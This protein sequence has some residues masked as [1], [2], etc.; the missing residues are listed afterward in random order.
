MDKW[1]KTGSLT[2]K[3][4]E[5]GPSTS[6]AA[7]VSVP[8]R[9]KHKLKR[10]KYSS[11]Y[12]ALGFTCT[13]TENEPLPLCVVCSE[14]LA[15]EALKTTKLRRHLETKH[16]EYASKPVEFFENKL[17]EYQSR[18]KTLELACSGTDHAKAVEASYR[19]AQLIAKAGKPHTI[20]E[21]LILPAA[22][23]MVSVMLGEKPCKQLNL[24]SLSDNT[25]ERRINE[26][27]HD[28]TQQLI[29]RVRESR[30]YAIQL[31]ESTDIANLSNLLAFVRYEH[32][33]EI[34]ED[35]LFCKPLPTKTTAEAIF[36]VL[37]ALIVSN[38]IE[39]SKC[40]GVST[41]GARAMMGQRSGVIASVKAVAPLA[42]SVHCSLHREALA[43]KRMSRDLKIVLDEAVKIV[44]FIKS[45]PL[46]S[47]L[48]RVLCEEMASS[49][50]QLLLH[51]E[52][53]WLSHGK[54]LARLFELRDEVRIFLLDSNFEL[55][56]RFTDFEWLAKLSYLS[57]I[58]T[59]LNGLN[60]SLQGKSVTAFHVQNK[61]EATI[62]KLDMWTKRVE[63]SNYE[64][65]DNLSDFLTKE[66]AS[67]PN[68]VSR[69]I[70]E[71]LQSLKM[72]LRDY[73]PALDV[74]FSWIENPFVDICQGAFASLSA[75][76]ED[77]LIDLSC[78][79]AL[80]FIF[81]QKSLVNFW[82]HARSEYPDLSDKAVRFLMP[83]PTTYLCETGFSMLVV[84]KTKYRN[85]LNVEPDLRLQL[86]ALQPDIHHLVAGKQ[87]QP[88]H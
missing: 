15:N 21:S 39:W 41:D 22:K 59:H 60:L 56:D 47:R 18:K 81:S 14:V 42:T 88:S 37:N 86:S 31:D 20:G 40:V 12:L 24:I 53:R 7:T 9:T 51:T 68:A 8:E 33:R 48:F 5:A 2:T 28:V 78:D 61:I 49:H 87:H 64:S 32:N 25:V 13:G 73:F 84:L 72:Q 75:S 3:D 36:D 65:F 74:H 69:P 55:S 30:F 83:F 82:L 29:K 38:G 43:A 1:L 63:Q 23:E 62:K 70:V 66:N 44:N 76:E 71:H 67:L 46:Q 16:S 35:I 52:V 17:K 80:K 11:E 26:M 34:F 19:V 50:V 4:P 58:F 27:A 10:R 77:R 54:V 85:R 45:R 57:D 79:S 6:E